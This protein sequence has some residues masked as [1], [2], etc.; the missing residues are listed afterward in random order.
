MT[1]SVTVDKHINGIII[2]IT[3]LC[4][5]LRLCGFTIDMP[6]KTCIYQGQACLQ[7]LATSAVLSLRLYV[8]SG[9]LLCPWAP[10]AGVSERKIWTLKRPF[11][12]LCLLLDRLPSAK[13]KRTD[14]ATSVAVDPQMLEAAGEGEQTVFPPTTDSVGVEEEV[15]RQVSCSLH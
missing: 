13:R 11:S 6:V 5:D 1:L 12:P 9:C 7:F 15:Q 2:I 3:V 10:S 8:S 4:R 14:A